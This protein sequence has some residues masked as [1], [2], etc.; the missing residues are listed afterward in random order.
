MPQTAK[1]VASGFA[2]ISIDDMFSIEFID[3]RDGMQQ[4]NY[5]GKAL[6]GRGIL[7]RVSISLRLL[8]ARWRGRYKADNP[9]I[10]LMKQMQYRCSSDDSIQ[11]ESC[12]ELYFFLTK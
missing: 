6:D 2:I 8:N 5:V 12:D 7:V 3:V 9:R 10:E 11:I 1:M 4:S